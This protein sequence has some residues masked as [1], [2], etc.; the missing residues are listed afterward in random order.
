M[1]TPTN[2]CAFIDCLLPLTPDEIHPH[3]EFHQ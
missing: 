3:Y 2:Y 1:T